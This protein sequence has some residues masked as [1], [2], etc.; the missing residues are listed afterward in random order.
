MNTPLQC[1]AAVVSGRLRALVVWGPLPA[2]ARTRMLCTP[3]AP[4]ALLSAGDE[5]V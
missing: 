5:T 2:W 1:F 3:S 4:V